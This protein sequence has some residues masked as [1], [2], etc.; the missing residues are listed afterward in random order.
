MHVRIIEES[1]MDGFIAVMEHAFG[2]ELKPENQDGFVKEFE[3]D[4]LIAAFDGDEVVGTG[5]AFTFDL[6]VPGGTVG[7]GGTTVI[8]VLPTHRRRGILTDMMRFH[9]DEVAGRGEPVAAL[10][11][12]ETPIYGR[13]GYGV[14]TRFHRTKLD[15]NRVSFPARHSDPVRH[16]GSSMW[17]A[18][19]VLPEFYE[20]LRPTRPGFLTHGEN[21]FGVGS[22]ST[23]RPIGAM[24]V[25]RNAWPYQESDGIWVS[26]STASTRNGTAAWPP[27][28]LQS[29]PCTRYVRR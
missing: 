11:A 19:G 15:R 6:T 20:R 23:T 12:S 25:P 16:S 5:G 18:R 27:I 14:A 1:D 10:W 7:C 3:L 29:A 21:R 4:R 22:F 8:A 2:F 28:G 9:L 24:G 13:F 17:R 26:P